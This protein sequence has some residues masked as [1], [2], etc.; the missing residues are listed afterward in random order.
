MKYE[1]VK[2]AAKAAASLLVVTLTA[3]CSRNNIEAIN[4]ANVGDKSLKVNVDRGIKVKLQVVP[5]SFKG[6]QV[7]IVAVRPSIA[8]TSTTSGGT[9][10]K[11]Q[12]TLVPMGGASRDIHPAYA[13]AVCPS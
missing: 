6:E 13:P 10:T 3:G 9:V 4:L 5:D 8:V 1:S 2:R 7:E 12:M 11:E